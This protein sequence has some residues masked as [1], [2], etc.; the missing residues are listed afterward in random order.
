MKKRQ[1]WRENDGVETAAGVAKAYRK[2]SEINGAMAISNQWRKRKPASAGVSRQRIE[3]P[4]KWRIS[5]ENENIS[6]QQQWRHGNNTSA[7]HGSVAK[8][9]SAGSCQCENSQPERKWRQ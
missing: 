3:K 5:S 2:T 9:I 4:S 7:P 8:I 6:C 1:Q